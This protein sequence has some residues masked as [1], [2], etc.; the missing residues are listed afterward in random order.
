MSCY[1]LENK[2]FQKSSVSPEVGKAAGHQH[3]D[4]EKLG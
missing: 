1:F 2:E 4:S 3:W